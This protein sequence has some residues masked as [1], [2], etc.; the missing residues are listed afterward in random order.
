MDGKVEAKRFD[1]IVVE[2][3]DEEGIK[4]AILEA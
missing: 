2:Q 1:T 4:K 3:G